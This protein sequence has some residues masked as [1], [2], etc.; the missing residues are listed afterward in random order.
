LKS[1]FL[2][3]LG[4]GAIA[5][6]A[7]HAVAQ[8]LAVLSEAPGWLR[9]VHY[10]KSRVSPSGYRSAIHS[11]EFFLSPSGRDDP[12]AELLAT[13]SAFSEA[14]GINPDLH[15]Q[16]RFPARL[17]W[18]KD[19]LPNHA[20]AIRPVECPGFNAWTRGGTVS[21]LSVVLATGYLGNPASYYGHTLLKFNFAGPDA[22]SRLLDVSV[23]YGAIIESD[24]NPVIY[25]LKS[26]TGGYDG[27]FS[28][29]Q[30]YFH[31]HNYGENELRDLW[32]YELSI[33]PKDVALIV[34]HSWEILK[35]R[36]VYEF[37][38]Y[39]CTMRMAQLLEVPGTVSITPSRWPW[40]IPQALVQELGT[41]QYEGAPLLSH[42]GYS[43]SRQ[44]RFIT[45][46]ENLPDEGKSIL[47]G[48]ALGKANANSI[49]QSG[50]PDEEKVAVV[51]TLLD[52]YQFANAPMDKAPVAIRQAYSAALG[53][54]FGLPP[55]NADPLVNPPDPPHTGRAPGRIYAAMGHHSL[56]GST[57]SVGVRA[58]YYDALDA[59]AAH[60]K[61]ASL[62][63]G[64]LQ[65]TSNR[66][67]T[68]VERLT[69]V[70]IESASPGASGLPGD[71]GTAWKVGFGMDQARL[72][73]TNCPVVRLHGDR[74][75]GRQFSR[76]VYG[77]MFVGAALQND[78][79]GQGP[80]LLRGT[81]E[82]VFR[83]SER[84]GT[85]LSFEK[86]LAIGGEERSYETFSADVRWAIDSWTDLRLGYRRDVA[87]TLFLGVGLYW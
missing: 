54:R 17:A 85:K 53:A 51:Q 49:L 31:N 60:V 59:G 29:V 68:F 1:A 70:A 19:A 50:R 24:D 16:C 77:A 13:W 64:D 8:D 65:L 39:N 84:F 7:S 37:F 41:A 74:G 80:G 57:A 6:G 72:S 87:S 86:R 33:G 66:E 55:D 14:P 56:F 28:H 27:G 43:P 52:Y 34:A 46:F 79:F 12:R 20:R 15:A 30:F 63:M 62:L 71:R 76:N 35:Q 42:I 25:I 61:N 9:L 58:A 83:P 3:A 78:R 73:C 23:N 40:I 82:I 69:V 22:P 32:E 11:R 81:G 26:I 21:S 36:F 48:V 44:T 18:L 4:A 10:D 5:G 45:G 47:R 75:I 2:A 38:R 67:S